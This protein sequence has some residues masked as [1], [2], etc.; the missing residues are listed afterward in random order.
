M[1]TK[2]IKHNTECL[3][4]NGVPCPWYNTTG[5]NSELYCCTGYCVD[6]LISLAK[7]INFTFDLALSPDGQFGSYQYVGS[8]GGLTVK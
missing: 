7:K 8:K 6:L 1:H 2:K 4:E 5:H 3:K